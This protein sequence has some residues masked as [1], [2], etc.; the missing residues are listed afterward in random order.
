M[1]SRDDNYLGGVGAKLEEVELPVCGL[2]LELLNL[3]AVLL[4]RMESLVKGQSPQSV[5][6]EPV[7][8]SL[9]AV[10]RHIRHLRDRD[11][12]GRGVVGSGGPRETPPEDGHE[13]RWHCDMHRQCGAADPHQRRSH[14]FV[15]VEPG[16]GRSS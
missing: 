4:E 5:P 2:V 10:A 15:G 13:E 3:A 9:P 16:R 8:P 7:P 6:R 14:R 12:P 11:G 1:P